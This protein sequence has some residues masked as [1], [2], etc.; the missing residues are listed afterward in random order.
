MCIHRTIEDIQPVHPLPWETNLVD[1]IEEEDDLDGVYYSD[2]DDAEPLGNA[3]LGMNSNFDINLIGTN[4]ITY[5]SQDRIVGNLIYKYISADCYRIVTHHTI[6]F[7][8][9]I[10]E[11]PD[12]DMNTYMIKA[13]EMLEELEWHY[14]TAL[15]YKNGVLRMSQLEDPNMF[16]DPL[17]DDDVIRG[18]NNL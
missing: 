7:I 17:S 10:N 1:F 4:K 6:H 3:E 12:F 9:R 18:Y 8:T 5:I 13:E 14:L 11:E 16:T 15:I 2:S